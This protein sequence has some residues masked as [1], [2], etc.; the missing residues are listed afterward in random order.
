MFGGPSGG[1]GVGPDVCLWG[2]LRD[3]PRPYPLVCHLIDAAVV[4]GELWDAWVDA[5]T[6]DRIAV[7]LGVPAD[8]LRRLV[9]FWAG[10]HDIGK[11]S[12]PFQGMDADVFK[13][14]IGE[15]GYQAS[16]ASLSDRLHHSEATHW[17]LTD[18]LER[19]GYPAGR[20]TRSTA[21]NIAQL[22][23]GHHGRFWRALS[24]RE[25]AEPGARAGLGGARWGD[26]REAHVEVLRVLTDAVAVPSGMLSGPSAVVVLG[27][28]IVADWLVSQESFIV[29]RL[30]LEGWAG[31]QAELREHWRRS[32]A[33]AP[34][35]VDV[36]GLRRAVFRDE[37]F[38]EQF[39]F[40]ANRLQQSL[41]DELPGLVTGPGLLLVTAPPGDGKTEAA[42]FAA[43]VFARAT[44]AGGLVFCLPTMATADAMFERVER[45][46]DNALLGD[47]AVTRVHGMAWLGA[48]GT[49]AAVGGSRH[50]VAPGRDAAAWLFGRRRGALAPL[51]VMTIDQLLAGVLPTRY[52]TLRLAG[53][54]GKV[55]VIDEAHAYGPWMQALLV[56]LLEWLGALHV[57]VVLLSATL[58]GRAAEALVRAYRDGAG[59]DRNRE[60]ALE[61]RYPGWLYADA[62][63]VH[64]PRAVSS[65]RARPL[66]V[67][68]EPVR[69]DVPESDAGHRLAVVRR[70]L[71][72]V[73]RD[74]GSVLVC[75]NTVAEAQETWRSLG[76][77]LG[78]RVGR[79][80][81]FVE[82]RLLHSRFR[83][84]DRASVTAECDRAFGKGPGGRRPQAAV[85]VATQI[86]EQSLDHDYDLVI[87]DLAPLAL[88]IQR[89]GRCQRHRNVTTGEDP[90]A[91]RRPTWLGEGPTI[92]VLDPVDGRGRFDQPKAWGKVYD[93]ALLH[94]TH[95]LVRD[96]HG[97]V[98]DIPKDV[99]RLVDA[100]YAEDFADRLD[101]AA[102]R[103]H[104]ARADIERVV[105]D[106]AE[107]QVAAM[108]RIRSPR[109]VGGDLYRLSSSSV[110]VD[111]G[112]I[113]TRLGADSARVVCLYDQG[114]GRWTLD[115]DGFLPA[116]GADGCPVDDAVVRVAAD[117]V[118]PVPGAWLSGEADGPLWPRW[119]RHAVL[120][121]WKTVA[122]VRGAS[123]EW[124]G[125]LKSGSASYSCAQ[126]FSLAGTSSS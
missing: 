21:H 31:T 69:R 121:G 72:P 86:V 46:R 122:F 116:P 32:A 40:G 88:L 29:P 45:F 118:I 55:V 62:A 111:E 26:Q 38:E 84:M 39:G 90:H 11:I 79:G 65:E 64:E 51:S 125:R 77:W 60:V 85:L 37:G 49:D 98:W 43:S 57:P 24:V 70:L 28:V 102:E 104:L 50:V 93:A 99:Q 27:V 7:E 35:V 75:C 114:D 100:V 110:E 6:A 17:A 80:D 10:L 82:L 113:A 89:S 94:R 59:L 119:K 63:A 115:E 54:A 56:R 73:V 112:L 13:R 109:G 19:M 42:L 12:P 5:A 1:C 123:G 36:A 3:L 41:I 87:S 105:D 68:R 126:G 96:A 83:A 81:G 66:T 8:D 34:A 47:A 124:S 25:L 53:A 71:E 4:A 103:E 16:D 48:R 95:V 74:G 18:V 78:D 9:C 106:M 107:Q 15:F 23:G 67:R 44:G 2:K 91:G 108:V 30:P 76:E 97:Q 14:L 20:A 33:D 58:T 117:F 52:N 92:A 22:L 120:Q 101:D 61:P